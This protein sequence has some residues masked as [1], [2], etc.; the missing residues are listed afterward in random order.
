MI[1]GKLCDSRGPCRVYVGIYIF[2]WKTTLF[3]SS[4]LRD[5]IIKDLKCVVVR[6][7]RRRRRRRRPSVPI[8]FPRMLISV[9]PRKCTYAF[10][11]GNFYKTLLEVPHVMLLGRYCKK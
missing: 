2:L 5:S 8:E 10:P 3:E 11:R 6:R 7:R 1:H 9:N 4:R